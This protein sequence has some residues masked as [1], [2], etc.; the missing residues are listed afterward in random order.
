MGLGERCELP[1]R[2]KSN[3]VHFSL[4]ISHMM[5][6]T[7]IIFLKINWPNL[8]FVSPSPPRISVTRL[9][10]NHT[11]TSLPALLRLCVNRNRTET[12]SFVGAAFVL[13]S[14]ALV[15]RWGIMQ[16]PMISYRRCRCRWWFVRVDLPISFD[17]VT[18]NAGNKDAHNSS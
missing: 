17:N 11:A 6:T 15:D 8:N 13:L 16:V 10:S 4:K 14:P 5:P 1:E 7:L 9:V 12:K 18:D 3:L 2:A